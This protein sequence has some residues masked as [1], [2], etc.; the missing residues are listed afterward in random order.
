MGVIYLV[1]LPLILLGLL[2]LN[3]KKY[4]IVL[5][6]LLTAPLASALAVDAPNASRSLVFLPTWQIL[7]AIGLLTL[8]QMKKQS[9]R[10]VTV[11]VFCILVLLNFVYFQ[12]NYF[13]HTNGEYGI[14][15]QRGYKEAVL[16]AKKN[17]NDKR[18]Y[19]SND[20]EQAYIFY[21]FYN[22][23]DPA[24]YLLSGGSERINNKCYEIDNVLFGVCSDVVPG[25]ILISQNLSE[26]ESYSKVEDIKNDDGE[27]VGYVLE[28]K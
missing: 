9:F 15:W 27:T 23:V 1:S 24:K 25:M 4:W 28:N 6:W 16:M 14:Y 7:E 3:L 21:L 2:K 5:F 22:K 26:G 12:H 8:L 18:V 13:R 19:V 10:L 17:S 20:Y 11:S